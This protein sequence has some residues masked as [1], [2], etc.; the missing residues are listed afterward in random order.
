M[1]WRLAASGKIRPMISE[2]DRQILSQLPV[3]DPTGDTVAQRR[4]WEEL[5]TVY[6]Q[7]LPAIGGLEK[8]SSYGRPRASS[9]AFLVAALARRLALALPRAARVR[10]RGA[11]W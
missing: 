7:D 11:I 4:A 1:C 3:W 6:N 5:A 2:H 8:T 9:S 10:N